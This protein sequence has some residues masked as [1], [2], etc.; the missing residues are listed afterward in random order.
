MMQ[1][2]HG[3]WMV[4]SG[5][6]GFSMSDR[7]DCHVYLLH[8]GAEGVLVDAG[9]GLDAGGI[10]ARISR[11][12]IDPR[13]IRRILLTHCHADHAAGAAA[14]VVATGAEVFCSDWTTRVLAEADED[15]AG[16]TA[17]RRAGTYPPE[18]RLVPTKATALSDGD[19]VAIAG[20]TL[21]AVETPGHARGHLCFVGRLDEDTIAFTGDLVFGRGRVAV[22]A[23]ADTDVRSFGRS[24]EH[25]REFQPDVLLP[26]HGS[27]VLSQAAAHL[28]TA[29]ADLRDGVLPRALS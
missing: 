8:D 28:D 6:L 9:C 19:Q 1:I 27:L 2:Q 15:A 25:L 16:L 29:L 11:A 21:T 5:W 10:L 13:S 3:L 17:A 4:A 22:L 23:T 24:I 7:H 12:G 20:V 18:V 14:L 26:G